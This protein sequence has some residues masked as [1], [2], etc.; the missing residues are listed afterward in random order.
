MNK[1]EITELLEYRD[2]HLIWKVD[3]NNKTKAG[4]KAGSLQSAGYWQVEIKGKKHLAHRLIFFLHHEYWPEEVDH[5]NNNKLDNRIENLRPATRAC[6]E[7]NQAMPLTNTSGVKNVDWYKAK[8]KWRVRI[9]V[10]TQRIVI[11]YFD[12][13]EIA[14]QAAIEARSILHGE[15]ANHGII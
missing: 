11:G 10:N 9:Q 2:G 5:I 12:N 13:L 7:W 6:N 1:S 14:K 4:Q 8:E 3:R 15:F